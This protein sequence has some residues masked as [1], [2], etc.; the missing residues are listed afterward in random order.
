MSGGGSLLAKRDESWFGCV[1]KMIKRSG[2]TKERAMQLARRSRSRGVVGWRRR[3]EEVI[4]IGPKLL[5]AIPEAIH[6]A[7]HVRLAKRKMN[8]T[9]NRLR[10]PP[11]GFVVKKYGCD[12]RGRDLWSVE[13]QRGFI[14]LHVNGMKHTD[15]ALAVELC[16]ELNDG[17]FDL[18]EL[19]EPCWDAVYEALDDGYGDD[20][21][22]VMMAVVFC[23]LAGGFRMTKGEIL[24]R[25]YVGESIARLERAVG[26]FDMG[27]AAG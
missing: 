3:V 15:R 21:R 1:V 10:R 4:D 19:I 18:C 27:R 16:W 13:E 17:E 20:E 25:A 6:D 26:G 9:G 8:A 24:V 14:P 22:D 12:R 5:R 2:E 23:Y 11:P 7:H